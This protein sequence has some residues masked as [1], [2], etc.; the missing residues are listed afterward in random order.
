[1][2]DKVDMIVRLLPLYLPNDITDNEQYFKVLLRNMTP[3]S[4]QHIWYNLKVQ[5]YILIDNLLFKLMRQSLEFPMITQLNFWK[6]VSS[7][8]FASMDNVVQNKVGNQNHPP[9]F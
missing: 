7:Q 6:I 8:R 9:L 5:K 2:D 1:M 4:L 3:E